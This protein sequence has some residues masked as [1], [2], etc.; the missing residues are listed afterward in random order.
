MWA[1]VEIVE[2][3]EKIIGRA[4]RPEEE[5]SIHYLNRFPPLLLAE[6]RKLAEHSKVLA[7][8]FV[9]FYTGIEHDHEVKDFVFEVVARDRDPAT[10]ERWDR[11]FYPDVVFPRDLALTVAQ[12]L[13]ALQ[14]ATGERWVRLV[15]S[16]RRGDYSFA[17]GQP[18]ILHR[19][20]DAEWHP[21]REGVRMSLA[22]GDE[23]ERVDDVGVAVRRWMAS[24]VAWQLAQQGVTLPADATVSDVM[25]ALSVDAPCSVD[26]EIAI[27]G[28]LRE[29]RELGP[30]SDAVPG[31]RGPDE[32]YTA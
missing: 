9:R 25:T 13:S 15:P 31:F 32:W 11:L 18:G 3:I 23:L 27:R 2:S 14:D 19:S 26:A 30:S 6:A 5:E 29:G 8:H 7:W 21:P 28:L 10:W 16:R 12:M 22:V 20:S 17:C 1:P 4:L 24:R